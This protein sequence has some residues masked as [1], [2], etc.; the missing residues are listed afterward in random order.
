MGFIPSSLVRHWSPSIK[1]VKLSQK[2]ETYV[3]YGFGGTRAEPNHGSPSA[4]RNAPGGVSMLIE[5]VQET[6]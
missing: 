1:S 3:R 5:T 6:P 2:G 4:P